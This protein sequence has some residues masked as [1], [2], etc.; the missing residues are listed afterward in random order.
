MSY[1]L[2]LSA[3]NPVWFFIL[4]FL[5]GTFWFFVALV[6]QLR[7]LWLKRKRKYDIKRYP[8]TSFGSKYTYT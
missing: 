2:A 7:Q 4:V 3:V 8:K 1:F 5:V 6:V